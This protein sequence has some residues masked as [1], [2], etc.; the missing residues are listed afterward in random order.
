MELSGIQTEFEGYDRI[1]EHSAGLVNERIDQQ[2]RARIQEYAGA[3]REDIGR[4]L[5]ELDRE[6]DVDRALMANFAVLGGLSLSLGLR[7]IRALRKRN[8]WLYL[9]GTQMG[10]LLMHAIVGWCP[11][12]LVFRRLGF[13]TSKEM[14]VERMALLNL[15]R[16]AAR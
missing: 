8:G 4:R 6:W 11:P 15:L 5:A 12:A 13:R 3:S 14:G 9:F 10:F 2:T 1:R 7:S 16:S